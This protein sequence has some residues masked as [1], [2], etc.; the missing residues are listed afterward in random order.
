VGIVRDRFFAV[1]HGARQKPD[2]R[3]DD[4]ERGDLASGED[5][6]PDAELFSGERCACSFVDALVTTTDEDDGLLSGKPFGVTLAVR[7]ALRGEDDH[8]CARLWCDG[9]Y[10][11]EQR[12]KAHDHA[13]SATERGVVDGAVTVVGVIAK[14][15]DV[16]GGD[17]G[18]LG[19]TDDACV[20]HGREH[21]R[22][23][24]YDVDVH[25]ASARG[26]RR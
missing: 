2:K 6:V 7:A 1:A 4:D 15:V 11:L 13:R 5:V 3:V 24:G 25:G 10:G 8:G 18:S 9:V 16:D 12:F 26:S 17:P 20:Q 19:A 14:V 22:E 21:L 23:D